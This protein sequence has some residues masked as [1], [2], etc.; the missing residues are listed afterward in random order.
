ME[1]K[2]DS[3]VNTLNRN[4]T[5]VQQCVEGALKV[6]MLEDKEEEEEKKRRKTSII[7]HGVTESETGDYEGRMK[8]DT[9]ILQRVLSYC[10]CC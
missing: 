10:C 3:I 4:A 5:T 7:V 6:H 1:T 9:D 8:D 2:V